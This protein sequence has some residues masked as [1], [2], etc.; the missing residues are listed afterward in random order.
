MK[1]LII[2]TLC[3]VLLI[4]LLTATVSAIANDSPA[5]TIL[6]AQSG[7]D[8]FHAILVGAATFGASVTTTVIVL[9]M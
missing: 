5:P 7:V 6:Q 2:M 8:W 9:K 1:R 3:L 4:G